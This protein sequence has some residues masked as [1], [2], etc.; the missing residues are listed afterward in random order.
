MPHG[1]AASVAPLEMYGLDRQGQH[2]VCLQEKKKSGGGWG[3]QTSQQN[4][5]FLVLS[6]AEIV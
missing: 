2:E 3:A 6:I 4:K 5:Y 1:V